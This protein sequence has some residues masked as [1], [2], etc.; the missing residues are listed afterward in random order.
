MKS[1]YNEFL[2]PNEC[3]FYKDMRGALQECVYRI[4]HAAKLHDYNFRELSHELQGVIGSIEADFVINRA[5][6]LNREKEAVWADGA[7]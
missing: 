1:I 3:E 6:C 2:N 4:F 5:E 7:R